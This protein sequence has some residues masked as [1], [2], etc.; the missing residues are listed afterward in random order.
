MHIPKKGY[1]MVKRYGLYARRIRPAFR[2]ALELLRRA[3]QQLFS[4]FSK[5]ITWRQRIINSFRKDPLLC[6]ICGTEMELWFIWHP[7]YGVLYDIIT[8]GPFDNGQK[9]KQQKQ[10]NSRPSSEEIQLYLPLHPVSV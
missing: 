5:R 10:E 3:K 7:E 2:K 6:P 8:D 1:Q 9:Q 4:F